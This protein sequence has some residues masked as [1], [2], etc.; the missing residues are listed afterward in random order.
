[1]SALFGWGWKPNNL[2]PVACVL[3]N[4]MVNTLPLPLYKFSESSKPLQILTSCDD[5]HV[6]FWDFCFYRLSR[7]Y[8]NFI[9]ISNADGVRRVAVTE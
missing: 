8:K 2:W 4:I 6:L 5:S 1:M 3:C 7:D 9:D